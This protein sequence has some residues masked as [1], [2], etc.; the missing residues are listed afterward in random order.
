MKTETILHWLEISREVN[1]DE[2]DKTKQALEETDD[3]SKMLDLGL[4]LAFRSGVIYF[5]EKFSAAIQAKDY[6]DNTDERL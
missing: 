1:Q 2:F 5:C 6:L 3:Q 4:E